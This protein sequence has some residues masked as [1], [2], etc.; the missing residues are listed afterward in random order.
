MGRLATLHI[1]VVLSL[2]LEKR[3]GGRE[4]GEV[5]GRKGEGRGEEMRGEEERRRGE[6]RGEERRGG[7][8]RFGLLYVTRGLYTIQAPFTAF[9][10]DW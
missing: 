7:E 1:P 3:E 6:G 10:N 8:E 4:E 5:K 9:S 2:A